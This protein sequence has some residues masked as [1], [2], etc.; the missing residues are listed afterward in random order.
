MRL[1]R[2]L[3]ARHGVAATDDLRDAG[4]TRHDLRRALAA[5]T[6]V[7][8]RRGWVALPGADPMLQRAATLGVTITCVTRAER[9]GLWT[10]GS[11]DPH[12]AAPSNGRVLAETAAHVHWGQPVAPRPRHALEDSIVNALGYAAACQPY[13]KALVVWESAARKELIDRDIVKRLP[14]G[15]QARRIMT[16]MR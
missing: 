11:S 9:A 6:V 3:K 2:E 16:E 8:L 13:E 14:F 1:F 5:G 12:V 15:P 4:V 10:F 7:R